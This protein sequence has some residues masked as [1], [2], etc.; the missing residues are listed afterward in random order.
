MTALEVIC[1]VVTA[2]S[3]GYHFGRRAGS[4][5][6]TWRSR[7]RRAALGRRAISLIG[8]MVASRIQRSVQRKLPSSRGWRRQAKTR[9]CW[10]P[11]DALLGRIPR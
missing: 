3:I 1:T 4:T 6:S 7:T 9:R 2:M 10:R 11:V 8:L 5:T